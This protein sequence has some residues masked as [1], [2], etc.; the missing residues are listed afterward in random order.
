MSNEPSGP[1]P[2][3]AEQVIAKTAEIA[4]LRKTLRETR[5]EMGKVC[6]RLHLARVERDLFKGRVNWAESKVS[7]D[8]RYGR[9]MLYHLREL[10]TAI[11]PARPDD[12]GLMADLHV[13][14]R[15]VQKLRVVALAADPTLLDEFAEASEV[16]R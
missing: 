5:R 4:A 6:E 3:L 13:A 1:A 15:L 16:S 8:N 12:E 7:D 11:N 9:R 10:M 2:D 14:M